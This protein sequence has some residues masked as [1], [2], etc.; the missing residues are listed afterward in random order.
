ML[1]AVLS[2]EDCRALVGSRSTT[3]M[4]AK[5]PAPCDLLESAKDFAVLRISDEE[6]N[7]EW[8]SGFY[9]LDGDILELNAALMSLSR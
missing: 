3:F 6:A 2:R 8:R 9:R 7:A 5:F 4:G 1:R